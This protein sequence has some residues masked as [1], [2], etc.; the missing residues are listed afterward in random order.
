[1]NKK[2]TASGSTCYSHFV[3]PF[4]CGSVHC[5]KPNSALGGFDGCGGGKDVDERLPRSC[6]Q[7]QTGTMIIKRLIL[8]FL[9][10]F[11]IWVRQEQLVCRWRNNGYTVEETCNLLSLS[12]SCYKNF[13]YFKWNCDFVIHRLL[14]SNLCNNWMYPFKANNE[15]SIKKDTYFNFD[16]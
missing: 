13:S 16:H 10:Q 6:E 3:S 8:E 7:N 11:M 2:S 4:P 14:S 9:F 12:W 5:W 15:Y 1:L